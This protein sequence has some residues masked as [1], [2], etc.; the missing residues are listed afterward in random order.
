M[1]TTRLLT[2]SVHAKVQEQLERAGHLI[3][4]LPPDHLDWQPDVD[5]PR[6]VGRLIGHLMECAAGFCAVFARIEPERFARFARLRDL[7]VNHRCAPEEAL[8][9]LAE[10]GACI[11]EGFAAIDDARLAEFV[12]TVF[13]PQGETLLTLLLGNLEHFINHKQQLFF[14]L[15]MMGVAVKT[16]DLYQFRGQLPLP[17]SRELV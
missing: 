6:A 1:S 9:R 3:R 8:A 12:P 4:H 15:R 10:Y 17:G 7:P 14:Y 5:N 2:V 11:D 16:P 13:V